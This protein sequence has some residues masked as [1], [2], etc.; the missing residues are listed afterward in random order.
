M[1][2]QH[3]LEKNPRVQF[4]FTPTSSSWINAVEGWFSQLERRALYRG[5]FTSVA[6]LKA[7]LERF[8]KMHND[9]LAKP[10]VWT[11]PAAKI[12]AAVERAKTVLP[13]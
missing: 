3:W 13:N 10:F 8:V 9:V 1:E 5:I 2:V 7:E 4:H 12:L 6:E 11:K